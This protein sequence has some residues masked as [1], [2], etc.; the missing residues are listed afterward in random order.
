MLDIICVN[1]KH[2]KWYYS[3][4]MKTSVAARPVNKR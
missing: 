1:V 4:H 3:V 2:T